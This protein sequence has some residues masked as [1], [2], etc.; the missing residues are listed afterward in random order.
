MNQDTSEIKEKILSILRRRG[1]SLPVHIASE[2]GLSI[3]FAS[4]FLSELISERKIKI[5]SMKV[6]SSPV[7]LLP[8]QEPLLEKFSQHLKSK[9]KDAFLLLKEKKFL[10]DKKQDPAIRVALRAIKDFAIPFRGNE[11]IIWRYFIIP[12]SEFK[13]EEKVRVPSIASQKLRREY[14]KDTVLT[15]K[16]ISE[17]SEPISKKQKSPELNIFGK[18]SE[19][20]KIK[21]QRTIK[22]GAISQKKNEKFFNK[23]KEFLSKKSIEIIDIESFNKNDLILRVKTSNQEKLVIAY[24][25]KRILEE[26]IVKA[27]KKSSELNLRY[28]ILSLGGPSKSLISLIEA[29]KNLSR[30]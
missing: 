25:K 27:N 2:T 23:V 11:E 4:A 24:N 18:P 16:E 26:D 13:T 19:K 22:K 28:I 1:P 21:K 5:S 17:R 30:I 20:K 15:S 6:G 14:K 9:E 8:K 10:R 29:M 3:L 7:Y 12:E